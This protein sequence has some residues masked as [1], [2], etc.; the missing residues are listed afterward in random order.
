MISDST[1][2]GAVAIVGRPNVGKSSVFNRLTG[3]R[4]AI[5]HEERGVTRDR[6]IEEAQWE[7]RRFELI[8]TGGLG[9]LEPIPGGAPASVAEIERGV[10]RQAEAAIQDA[11]AI[12]FVTDVE[13]G[14]L[15][16]DEEVAV[17][18]RKSG[19][20]VFLA[21]N[22]ADNPAR[23]AAV[24][25]FARL[26]FPAFPVSVLHNRG[27]EPLMQAVIGALPEGEN[28]TVTH[29]LKIAFVGRPNV[30]KSSV[31][32]RVLRSDRVIVSAQPG[33]T[34]DSINIPFII[35]RDALARHYILTDTAG[36]RRA[37]KIP[38]PVD[39]LGVV[40][41]EQSIGRADVVGL[42]LDA[43]QGP[44]AQDKTIAALIMESRKGCVL[45][46]NKWDLAGTVS[47][48]RYQAALRRAM[49]FCDFM[50][51]VLVSAKNGSNI[52][53]LVE[54][55]DGVA[56]HLQTILPTGVLNRVILDTCEKVQPPLVQGRRLRIFYATQATSRPMVVLLFVN[57]PRRMVPAYHTYLIRRLRLAFGLEGV[58][59][60]LQLRARRPP[61]GE[62]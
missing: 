6:L 48:A 23:D 46:V 57:D 31:I 27:F 26:G 38:G 10:R 11:A 34:R 47:E 43:A 45:V 25:D 3:R 62:Q 44:T 13:T 17:I 8:D 54:T 49:P 36:I 42:V 29:P 14:I 55:I 37:G 4:I 52:R 12:L 20:P 51:V 28:P 33:T 41:A 19:R 24:A 61:P 56:L 7:G 35:G 1:P 5:V 59:V 39:R 58:P 32:N 15:P 21:A 9:R 2:R 60:T 30:G 50:P 18:L 53:R 40:R 16:Q 22:K